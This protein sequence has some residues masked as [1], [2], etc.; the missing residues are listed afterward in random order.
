MRAVDGTVR[1]RAMAA[2][3]PPWFDASSGADKTRARGLPPCDVPR[4]RSAGRWRG[5]RSMEGRRL[6]V[7]T[8]RSV[9]ATEP[10]LSGAFTSC[11][12]AA[13]PTVAFACLDTHP[14]PGSFPKRIPG[15]Y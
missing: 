14:G 10:D 7:H 11:R 13:G 9:W 6:L 5:R 1:I 4:T 8:R 15:L 3:C 2:R 12:Q